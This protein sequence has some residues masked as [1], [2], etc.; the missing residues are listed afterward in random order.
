M[1][2]VNI[3]KCKIKENSAKGLL[4]YH[5]RG[6]TVERVTDFLC[7]KKSER[8]KVHSDVTKLSEKAMNLSHTRK[9]VVATASRC[10]GVY[11]RTGKP[12][13]PFCEKGGTTERVTDFSL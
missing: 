12:S 6:G 1:I 4:E 8:S 11:N 10:E 5:K 9:K 3:S 13:V 2:C 7:N